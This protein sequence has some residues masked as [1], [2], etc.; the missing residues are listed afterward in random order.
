MPALYQVRLG[1][2]QG[3]GEGD[4]RLLAHINPVHEGG[5]V[6][7]SLVKLVTR[8][9]PP[10]DSCLSTLHWLRRTDRLTFSDLRPHPYS[11]GQSCGG[12]LLR[13]SVLKTAFMD[14]PSGHWIFN[15]SSFLD[16]STN[17]H[18]HTHTHAHTSDII[19][20]RVVYRVSIDR[21]DNRFQ[22][23]RAVAP[24]LGLSS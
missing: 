1:A 13:R 2:S 10:L 14:S 9:D 22:R 21:R 11:L 16:R 18:A 17:I 24:V 5:D 8:L 15:L 7:H 19:D 4:H 20:L 6:R 3:G 23:S 12:G